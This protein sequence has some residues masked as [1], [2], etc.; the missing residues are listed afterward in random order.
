MLNHYARSLLRGH[1]EAGGLW[2]TDLEGGCLGIHNPHLGLCHFF[3]GE[4]EEDIPGMKQSKGQV[5]K[6][7]VLTEHID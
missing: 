3:A 7:D 2:D 1:E 4:H 6:G 5:Q